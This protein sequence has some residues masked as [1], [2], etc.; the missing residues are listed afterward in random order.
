V[1]RPLEKT[2]YGIKANIISRN[3]PM[4]TAQIADKYKIK[5][6]GDDFII[7]CSGQQKKFIL[8]TRKVIA[9]Q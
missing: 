7:A 1:I 3:H 5:D 9:D 4:T 6:G 2:D 8:L